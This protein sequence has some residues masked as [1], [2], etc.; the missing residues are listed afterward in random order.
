MG[1]FYA[2]L[3]KVKHDEL[4][5]PSSDK[6]FATSVELYTM[7]SVDKLSQ[8]QSNLFTDRDGDT[9]MVEAISTSSPSSPFKEKFSFEWFSFDDNRQSSRNT[10]LFSPVSPVSS[11]SRKLSVSTAS[12][13]SYFSSISPTA[14]DPDKPPKV[15][16]LDAR[17]PRP[18]Q[19]VLPPPP[20]EPL[21]WI[22]QCHMCRNRYPLA[23]TRRCLVDGHYYCSGTTNTT[24]KSSKRRKQNRSCTSEFDYIGWQDWGRWSR[25]CKALKSFAAG[26]ETG[27][28]LKGCESCNFPSQCRYEEGRPSQEKLDFSDYIDENDLDAM[29]VDEVDELL[30]PKREAFE[31]DRLLRSKSVVSVPNKAQTTFTPSQV[32]RNA[33]LLPKVEAAQDS[34]HAADRSTLSRRQRFYSGIT[35]SISSMSSSPARDNSQ[36]GKFDPTLP[37]VS[38][39]SVTAQK[40]KLENEG[41]EYIS[42]ME[43]KL[44]SALPNSSMVTQLDTRRSQSSPQFETIS[45]RVKTRKRLNSKADDPEFIISLDDAKRSAQNDTVLKLSKPT[46]GST[47]ASS[48]QSLI[49]DL[50]RQVKDGGVARSKGPTDNFEYASSEDD[51]LEFLQVQDSTDTGSKTTTVEAIYIDPI[52]ARQSPQHFEDI[53]LTP[54]DLK[55]G[56]T[57]AVSLVPRKENDDK[58]ID[59]DPVKGNSSTSETMAKTVSNKDVTTGLGAGLFGFGF[60]RK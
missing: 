37:S 43:A 33:T 7:S 40:Q 28:V 58:S 36:K 42:T 18:S 27:P 52:K 2:D 45:S 4:L 46:G 8:K 9:A 35:T 26:H 55:P 60:G 21:H 31:G 39:P 30:S 22:W 15:Y 14:I 3:N 41:V 23:V 5:K 57:L 17:R 20:S 13:S 34:R 56:D 11:I 1:R 12:P 29:L 6:L 32:A 51:I 59:T 49:T 48:D 38:L 25:K 24:Q 47:R 50:F 19:L 10:S 16:D 44:K 54:K 53:K